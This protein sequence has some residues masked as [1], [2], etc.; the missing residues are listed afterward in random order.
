MIT[1]MITMKTTSEKNL[2]LIQTI[3]AIA[4][5]TVKMVGCLRYD[6]YCD[7]KDKNSFILLVEWKTRDDLDQYIASYQF[8]VLLGTKSLLC[9]PFDIK[10]LTVLRSN[11][12]DFIHSIRDKK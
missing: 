6:I 9:E 1:M 12:M 2:E 3:R 5:H 4:E 11:G 10:I 7:L 8:S